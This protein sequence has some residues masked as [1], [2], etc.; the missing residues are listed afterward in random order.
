MNKEKINEIYES[1]HP[2]ARATDF[3]PIVRIYHKISR[4]SKCPYTNLKFK[5]CCGQTGQDFCNKAKDNLK[6]ELNKH[7]LEHKLNEE[8]ENKTKE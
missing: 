4:N 8:Q 3:S 6:E 5:K 1:H 2:Y 7:I